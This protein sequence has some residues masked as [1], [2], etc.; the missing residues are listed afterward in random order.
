MRYAQRYVDTLHKILSNMT[1]YNTCKSLIA[2]GLVVILWV[3]LP[4]KSIHDD[5]YSLI[6]Y[7]KQVRIAWV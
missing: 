7:W 4:H 2:I 6:Y 1:Q 3:I 5:I